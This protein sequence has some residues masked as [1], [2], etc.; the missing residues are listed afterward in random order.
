MRKRDELDNL[1]S[2]L[3]KAI[4][5]EM[6]FIL[7]ARDPVAADVIDYWV[8]LRVERGHNLP[9]DDQ[10]KEALQCASTMRYEQ[11]FVRRMLDG[12]KKLGRSNSTR[13]KESHGTEL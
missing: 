3:T 12:L 11:P 10:I 6:L 13:F 9:D 2:C 8:K 5:S 1:D 4:S 7:L